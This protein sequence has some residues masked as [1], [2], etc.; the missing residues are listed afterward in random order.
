MF[1]VPTIQF[2]EF[3][4]HPPFHFF[5]VSETPD[6]RTDFYEVAAPSFL[7]HCRFLPVLLISVVLSLGEL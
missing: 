7:H 1:Q 2:G 6:A 4:P 3:L 5:T